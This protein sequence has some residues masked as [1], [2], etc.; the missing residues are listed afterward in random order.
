[1]PESFFIFKHIWISWLQCSN[2]QSADL[3]QCDTT[4]TS[5]RCHRHSNHVL[6][7]SLSKTS[8]WYSLKFQHHRQRQRN[9]QSLAADT[10]KNYSTQWSFL[11]HHVR[12]LPMMWTLSKKSNG[13]YHLWF[14]IDQKAQTMITSA[15]TGPFPPL[16]ENRYKK[17]KLCTA[18]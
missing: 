14:H 10:H 4:W 6:P 13:I 16:F 5:E 3:N 1:M 7:Q 9:S 18:Q 11:D 15:F 17:K 2:R 12:H 8:L